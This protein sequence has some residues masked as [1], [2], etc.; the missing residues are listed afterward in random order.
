MKIL[1]LDCYSGISGDMFLGA[2][3]DAGLDVK[4]LRRELSSLGLKNYSIKTAR[5]RRGELNATKLDVVLEGKSH[6]KRRTLKCI[7]SLINSSGLNSDI[8]KKSCEIFKALARAEASVHGKSLKDLHFHEVGDTDS[9]IDVVGAVVALKA[10]AIDKVYSSSISV[11]AGTTIKTKGG[12]IP[13]PGPAT[14]S[15]LK[16]KPLSRS[17]S[18]HELVTPTGAALLDAFVDKFAYFPDM[19]LDSIGY[20]AGTNR[21]DPRPNC[22]RVLIGEAKEAFI[23]DS[24]FVI[25]ANVDDMNPVDYEYLVEKLFEAGALDVYLVPVQMK[26]MRP[27]ILLTVLAKRDDLDR[28]ST[29]IFNESTTI[30]VRF[31]EAS[32]KKLARKISSVKTRYGNVRFKVSCGPGG[33]K[34]AVPEYDDCKRIADSKQISITKVRREAQKAASRL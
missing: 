11:S 26:K 15:L 10:L 1:Y 30:G 4:I 8:K 24:I 25:E 34:K 21:L 16:G 22:L 3:V 20:G 5:V 33:I 29:I 19:I 9:I 27:G 2:L 28:L 23:H 7:T 14:L 17:D 31:Y 18:R 13:I 6:T 12:V 32:R